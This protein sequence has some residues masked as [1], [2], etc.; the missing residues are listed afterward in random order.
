MATQYGCVTGGCGGSPPSSSGGDAPKATV[1]TPGEFELNEGL[2]L[3]Y[4]GPSAWLNI[5]AQMTAAVREAV[6][7]EEEENGVGR[8]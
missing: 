6:D 3:A 4:K 1:F 5:V 2:L 7:E 8:S